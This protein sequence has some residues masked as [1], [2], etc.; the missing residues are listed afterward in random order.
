M[1]RKPGPGAASRRPSETASFRRFPNPRSQPQLP[2]QLEPSRLPNHGELRRRFLKLRVQASR[3][4]ATLDHGG[5]GAIQQAARLGEWGG[6]LVQIRR[7]TPLGLKRPLGLAPV[8]FVQI[9]DDLTG[10]RLLRFELFLQIGMSRE[11][12]VAICRSLIEP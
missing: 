11:K 5:F 10:A 4:L 1:T 12:F 7:E 9:G 6:A 2:A 8:L 3:P